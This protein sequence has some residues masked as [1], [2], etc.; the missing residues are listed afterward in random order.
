[1]KVIGL[2]WLGVRTEKFEET[3]RFYREVMGLEPYHQDD[4]SSRFRL[5]NGADVH[6]YG[7]RDRDHGFFGKGPVVGFLV[8]DVDLARVEM[9]AAGIEF[10]G[11]IQRSGAEAWN[12]F[13]GPDGNVY[14]IISGS[15]V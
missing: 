7:P 15:E 2:V 1:M 10:I 3:A 14:E 12:H 6:V 5:G 4:A 9:E 13:R 8:D 11:E